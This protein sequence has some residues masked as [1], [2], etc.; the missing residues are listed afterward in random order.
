[1]NQ[2]ENGNLK[3]TFTTEKGLSSSYTQ[4]MYEDK[5][6]SLIVL[7]EDGGVNRYKNGKFSVYIPQN[8]LQHQVFTI[9]R[10]QE[11]V[12]WMGS[13]GGGLKRYQN[14][15]VISIRR[16]NGLFED[17]VGNIL[18]DS[19]GIF[20]ISAA[21][22]IFTVSKKELNDF[23]AGKISSVRCNAYGK[24]EGMKS[25]ECSAG[26]QPAAWKSPDG[27]L[28]F[29]TVKGVVMIDPER[30]KTNQIKPP[31]Y[32]EEIIVDRKSFDQASLT[33][34]ELDPGKEKF[35]FRYTGLSF[36]DPKKVQFKY[37]LEGFDKDWV[38]AGTRRTAYYTNI[39]PRHY[40]FRVIASN[41]DGLWNETGASAS[42]H[43]KPYFY[44]TQWFY[45][46]CGMV[47]LFVGSGLH[48]V[49]VKKVSS[50]F[51]AVIAER[52]RI[53]REIHDGLAQA[54]AGIV[55]QLETAQLIPSNDK[56]QHH[57]DR[58]L[59]MARDGVQDARRAIGDLRP[60]PLEAQDFPFAIRSMIQHQLQDTNISFRFDLT[61]APLSIPVDVQSELLRICQ[62]STQNVIKHSQAQNLFVK[63]NYE[64]ES[65]QISIQDDGRGFRCGSAS[66]RRTL[67][68][69][70]NAGAFQ[71]VR[72]R[73][74]HSKFT[75]KRNVGADRC[76]D[77]IGG[78]I[79]NQKTDFKQ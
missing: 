39:P 25:V 6:G 27:K 73:I 67:R 44:Q 2:L 23:A 79:G 34:I 31:V 28:W 14:G 40:T 47:V 7:T 29:P 58:A 22:G 70:R 9:Y 50:E 63:M 45:L 60:T 32:I 17:F 78:S 51:R 26:Y 57:L 21:K 13:Y 3:E 12:L 35:E 48:R 46:V 62:E 16:S 19:K 59:E 11:G 4:A 55:M 33:K 37:K 54:L 8:L 49:R 68:I 76:T 71:A 20:W 75:R 41:N 72:H 66:T 15:K 69:I 10:D 64:N 65:T 5:D 1:M 74:I 43:M 38:D 53:A 52:S 24:S 42:F 61:G 36:I 30:L 77:S 56:S 18:E